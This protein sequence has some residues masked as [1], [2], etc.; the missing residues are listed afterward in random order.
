MTIPANT[1]NGQIMRWVLISGIIVL[2][3]VAVWL[4]KDILMLTLTAIIFAV[5]LT[6]PIRFFV[7]RGI[8]RPLGVLLTIILVIALIALATALLLPGLIQQFG[9]LISDYIPKAAKQIQEGLDPAKLVQ[10]FPFLKD[11]DL[12]TITDQITNQFLPGLANATSQLFPFVGSL[13]STLLSILIVVFLA[14]YFV[15]DPGMHERGLIKLLPVRYRTR[16][17]EILGKMDKVLRGYLQ[18]QIA[19][20]ILIGAGTGIAL[21][22]I[23]MPLAGVLGTLTGLLSFVPNFG[24]LV[25][26]VPILAVAMIN[27]P[28]KI[29][30]IVV[31]FYILQFIQTQIVAP[32]LMGQEINLPPAIILL[33]QIVAGIFFGFLG[34]LLSVPLAAIVMVLVQEIY[35]KD[36]LGDTDGTPPGG[37]LDVETDGV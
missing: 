37:E 3:F 5:L 26:L 30:L 34:L 22:I 11:I 2:I 1:Q 18:A 32:L 10:Q 29:V 16:G 25:A 13:A 20:M 31:V 33:S 28:E 14:L 23:G 8:P 7:R 12:K 36:V 24:P 19:L 6:T 4:I 35:I 27:T 9:L 21:W 15:A 17:L